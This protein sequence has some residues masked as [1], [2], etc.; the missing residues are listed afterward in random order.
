MG[1]ADR[2]EIT[3]VELGKDKVV[4]PAAFLTALETELERLRYV[5][6]VAHRM[7]QRERWIER[8]RQ[9]VTGKVNFVEMVNGARDKTTQHLLDK[10]DIA[11]NPPD[12][13]GAQ[14][15]LDFGYF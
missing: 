6:E 3:G 1:A 4:V 10:L 2:K 8:F 14:S 15:W 7:G 9:Q 5:T 13:F 12:A 11:N